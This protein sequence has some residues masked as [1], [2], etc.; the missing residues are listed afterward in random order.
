MLDPEV[1]ARAEMRAKRLGI[2]LSQLIR[3]SLETEVSLE[4]ASEAD[5]FW[6]DSEIIEDQGP[7]DFAVNHD[8]YLYG[9]KE[10]P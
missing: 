3:K 6:A 2:S 8:E 5:P 9:R 7:T 1:K 10:R 4:P